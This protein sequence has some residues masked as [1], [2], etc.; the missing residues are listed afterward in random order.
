MAYTVVSRAQPL[1]RELPTERASNV[2]YAQTMVNDVGPMSLSLETGAN[3]SVLDPDA[4]RS[5]G[6][7]IADEGA[8]PGVGPGS[9]VTQLGR[10]QGVTFRVG[11]AVTFTQASMFVV[12]VR[13]MAAALRHPID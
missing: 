6:L 12:P 13:A 8:R 11:R 4:A 7:T 9:E 2:F 5:A 3:L 10:I 1:P